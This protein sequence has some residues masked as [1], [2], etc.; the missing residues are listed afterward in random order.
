M[1]KRSGVRYSAL[2]ISN[3]DDL[4]FGHAP[5]PIRLSNGLEIGGGTVYPEINFTLPPMEITAETMPDVQSQYADM[6]EAVCARAVE[7]QVPGLVVE[8][9]LLPPMT[10]EPEWGA[11][12][13]AI[14]RVTL[15]KYARADGLNC[16]LRVT[17]ND[18]RPYKRPPKLNDGEMRDRLI[19]SFEL[20]A[21]AGA[22]MLSIQS[23]GG[24]EVCDEA[25]LY[26]DLRMAVLAIG[27]L[28]CRDM[29]SLWDD[30]VMAASKHGAIAASDAGGGFGNTA[31]MLA[32][33]RYIPKVWAAVVRVMAVARSLVAYERGAI[34][35]SKNAAFEGPYI[36]AITGCP[37]SAA[38]A[39]AAVA[40]P[41]PFGNIARAAA[42]LIS[43]ESVQ[44]VKLLGGMAPVVSVEQ[45][46]YAVRLLNC[47]SARGRSVAL[48]IRDCLVESDARLDPQAFVLRPDVVIEIAGQIVA[49]P[50][51]YRRTRRAAQA[52]LAAL[53]AA[54]AN[55]QVMIPE[56]ELG[57][58][59]RLSRQAD[60]LPE[61]ENELIAGAARGA[62]SSRLRLQDYG[63]LA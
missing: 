54:H 45:L 16:A 48:N 60:Q 44:N 11:D 61:E 42:D 46:A 40:F 18:I 41:T 27:V 4:I 38:A 12:I 39:E 25:L 28:A 63:V 2:A 10:L 13:T 20:C 47:A 33:Q 17:P 31:M 8:F 62:D 58:L 43:N 56:T 15:D 19:R 23:I 24:K 1:T 52:A 49:E 14:L 26:G 7:L 53:R 9:D 55:G 32:Q 6:A 37:I 5:R 3:T 57:W 29:A 59:D 50:T 35:P 22:D 34:G 36:K 51:P 21:V 30:I